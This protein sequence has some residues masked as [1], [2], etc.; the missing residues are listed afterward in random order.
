MI[1]LDRCTSIRVE[2]LKRNELRL[3]HKSS[4]GLRERASE[5]RDIRETVTSA[6]ESVAELKAANVTVTKLPSPIAVLAILR[7]CQT[8]LADS[9]GESGKDFGRLKRATKK[10]AQDIQDIVKKAVETVK[11]DMPAIDEAFLRQVEAIPGYAT[12][13][14][15]IRQQR[16][17]LLS[18]GDPYLSAGALKQFLE[19]RFA[20]S[21]LADGLAPTE[22]PKEILDFFRAARQGGASLDKLTETVSSWLAERDLLKNVRVTVVVR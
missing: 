7:E 8:T 21:A 6:L 18:G 19:K 1:V 11:R 3:A 22:F 5:L 12:S 2:I 10:L 17:A 4:E 15:N 14:T 13:V 9:P 20:L 16:D